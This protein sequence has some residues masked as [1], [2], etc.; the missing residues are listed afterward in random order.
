MEQ[1]NGRVDRHGQ[2]NPEVNVHH[3]VGKGFDAKQDAGTKAPGD[4]EGDLEFL[5]RAALKVETIRE[6]LGK[7]GPV[8]AD[9][10]E[11]AM[12][13]RR[14]VLD[15]DRAEKDSAPVRQLLK[16]ERQLRAQLKKLTEQLQDTQRELRLSPENIQN[17][18]EVGLALAG[19]SSLRPAELKGVWPDST[20]ARSKCP[21]FF[22]PLLSGSWAQC[23]DGLAHPH[24]HRVRP[25][26]FDHSLATGRDDVVLC[27]LNHRLVQM[28]MRL[29]R[30]EIWSQGLAKKL[31]RFT[32]RI[33]EDIALQSPAVIIHGRLLVIGGDNQRV[34]EELIVAGCHIREGRLVR[35]NLTEADA[36]LAAGTAENAP[37]AIDARL[38]E[39]WPKIEAGAVQALEARTQERTKNLR[40]FLDERSEREVSHLTAVM[41]ELERSI[42][43]ELKKEEDPQLKLDLSDAADG[44][45]AQ[46]DRDLES[47]RDRLARIPS[48]IAA[49]T[50]HLRSRYKNP[51]PR[52]FPLAV[53]ILVPRR[54]AAQLNQGGSR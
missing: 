21:V 10:V 43:E 9:Q 23:A 46:R 29:L 19:Q 40:K 48:E 47:L 1:R 25:I 3:F 38:L 44:E 2:K 17:V 27:H 33:V 18:V 53:T 15:T 5:Y 42:R 39:L 4:L 6:D 35:M 26:V 20:G 51:Q 14:R 8:I 7:V 32:T 41:S 28:C 50:A 49:E 36:A 45:R 16:F 34:H 52:L 22:L 12:L 11:E 54:A 13:G 30:A 31:H 37:Q 24:T